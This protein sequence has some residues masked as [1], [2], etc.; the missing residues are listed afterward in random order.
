MERPW[1]TECGPDDEQLQEN[2]GQCYGC[3]SGGPAFDCSGNIGG[4]AGATAGGR[5]KCGG[6]GK[7]KRVGGF[8]RFFFFFFFFGGTKFSGIVVFYCFVENLA[9]EE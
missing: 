1:K 4:W 7:G 8:S 2:V 5:R 9:W 6:F 3:E